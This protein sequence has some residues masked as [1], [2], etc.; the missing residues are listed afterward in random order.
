MATRTIV[1][2]S[3]VVAIDQLHTQYV[4]AAKPAVKLVWSS[5]M[6]SKV[7]SLGASA[8]STPYASAIRLS[9][10]T[11]RHSCPNPPT[12]PLLWTGLQPAVGIGGELKEVAQTKRAREEDAARGAS[13]SMW[14]PLRSEPGRPATACGATERSMA[15]LGTTMA[16]NGYY[17][18][19]EES[20][21]GKAASQSPLYGSPVHA[22]TGM[23][24]GTIP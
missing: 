5:A 4:V 7:P 11:A 2:L 18:A 10:L 12:M 23:V 24:I 6:A 14:Q 9:F 17:N 8:L 3:I 1:Q 16:V 21:T 15:V 22:S 20:W 13:G 19:Q